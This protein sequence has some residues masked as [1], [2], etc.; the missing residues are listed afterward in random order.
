MDSPHIQILNQTVFLFII[1]KKRVTHKS[2]PICFGNA[3][4][5]ERERETGDPVG[6]RVTV[7]GRRCCFFFL[8]PRMSI[9]SDNKFF[10]FY[11][12]FFL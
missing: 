4:R 6:S 12:F 2:G 8:L 1:Q 3:R 10:V 11:S 7:D 9:V 5:L